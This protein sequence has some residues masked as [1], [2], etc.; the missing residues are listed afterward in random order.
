MNKKFFLKIDHEDI[1]KTILA[2]ISAFVSA[3][4]L[5]SVIQL[6]KYDVLRNFY[7]IKLV[8]LEELSFFLTIFIFSFMILFILYLLFFQPYLQSITSLFWVIF[9]VVFAYYSPVKSLVIGALIVSVPAL[10]ITLYHWLKV[11]L[12]K[13]IL[14]KRVMHTVIASVT[15]LL[16]ISLLVILS[17]KSKLVFVAP[18]TL[19]LSQI[20]DTLIY[21]PHMMDR[22]KIALFVFLGML[23]LSISVILLLKYKLLHLEKIPF[24]KIGY[25]IIAAILVAQV[26]T[27]SL[28]MSYRVKTLISSTYDFG[29]FLQMFHS[30]R[31]FN[32]MVTT[33]ERSVMLSHLQVHFSP[34]YYV[35]L[36][37]F[38]IFPY[39][40]TLQILQIIVVAI[41]VIPLWLITKEF[42][43]HQ[44]IRFSAIIMYIA[45][46]ALITSHFY[47]L[48]ENCFLAPLILFVLYFAIK[49]KTL[50][51]MLSSVLLLFVKEDAALY[52]FFIGIY[53]FINVL[54]SKSKS[55]DYRT[56]ISGMILSIVSVGY[57]LV[58]TNFLND[59][60]D[61]AMFWRYD[62]LL[63]TGEGSLTEIIEGFLLN[64]SYYLATFFAPLKINTIILL[65]ASVGFIPFL[66]KNFAGYILMVPVVIINYLS[67]YPYQHQFGFQYFYGSATLIIFMVLLAEKDHQDQNITYKFFKPIPILQFFCLIGISVSLVQGIN[68]IKEHTDLIHYYQSN[69]EQFDEMKSTLQ[70]IPSDKNVVASGFLTPYLSDRDYLYDYDYFRMSDAEVE[71]DYFIIDGRITPST[72]DNIIHRIENLNY[73]RSELST[74]YILIYEPI[75]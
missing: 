21:A 35:M 41:G 14:S 39:G 15:A 61:G 60:G 33:L 45:S 30:M 24:Q 66:M 37:I 18:D 70:S 6:Y 59:S 54:F 75:Q 47:D 7:N 73:R 25:I 29:I 36:P 48:H 40:E 13:E 8:N 23:M 63:L 49:R 43:T 51:L 56:L 34:I 11:H 42:K 52:L 50:L 65:L 22:W 44:F 5:S 57:F 27:L 71:I 55:K 20:S 26:V 69:A 4:F 17:V 16:F 68:Y 38:M 1:K 28:I 10:F 2:L 64:P 67:T 62:N 46:P 12:D 3:F 58:I 19:N 9:L 53:L 32:G 74:E 72:L 31:G